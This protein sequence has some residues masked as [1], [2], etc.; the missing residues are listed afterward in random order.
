MTDALTPKQT[1]VAKRVLAEEGS[2]RKH[3]V[4]ALSGSHSY[5]FASPDSDLDLKSIHIEETAK[6]LG[7][8]PPK[9][10]H[11]RLEVVDGI[12]IDYTSNELQMVLVG[13]LSGN[14][15]Y[16]ERILGPLLLER[17]P[18]LEGLQDI[19]RRTLSRRIVNHYRGFATSQLREAEKSERPTAKKILYVLRTALTGTH[20]LRTGKLVTDL[21]SL[22]DDY[23]LSE[24]SKLIEVK[25]AGE[26]TP[27]TPE[28]RTHWL[29]RIGKVFE[30]LEQSVASSVLPEDPTTVAE[31]ESWLVNL[32]K[33]RL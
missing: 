1:E 9:T 12:E 26:K 7:L 31:L 8:N 22:L 19:A 33:A 30:L 6:L 32:R 21:A 11:N 24:A 14:G 13:L 16:F 5:G 17:A 18:E 20:A 28:E 15:N 2:R 29:G 23:G 10:T 27:L 3:L 4:T 25:R